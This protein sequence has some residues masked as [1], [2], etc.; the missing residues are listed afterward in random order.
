MTKQKP[1]KLFKVA[2][3][4][5]VATQSIVD[6]LSEN[7]FDV[8]NRPNSSITAEMYEVL[9]GVY[10]DDKEKS[11]E[12]ERAREEYESRRNQ[13]MSS[14]NESVTIESHL[15]PMDDLPLE[16][17]EDSGPEAELEPV[18]DQSS[19]KE[20]KEKEEEKEEVTEEPE[21]V[22]EDKEEEE[23]AAEADDEEEVTAEVEEKDE[24]EEVAEKSEEVEAE[25]EKE[26]EEE[27][28]TKIEE[29][30]E[31]Q[32]EEEEEDD[33][34]DHEDEEEYEDE[35]EDEEEEEKDEEDGEDEEEDEED[36]D[37]VRGRAGRLSGTK[38]LGKVEFSRENR[39]KR[40]KR[41]RRK[42][43]LDPDERSSRKDKKKKTKKDDDSSAKSSKKSKKK[44]SR[45]SS[46]V[47]EEDVEKKM[48]ETLQRIKEGETV[49]SKR[50]KRRKQRREEREEERAQQE[51]LEELE[52]TT[53]E[54]TEFITVSDLA[55]LM[56]V[57]SNDVIT[58]CMSL[59]MMVSINQRLDAATIELVAEEYGY[60]VEFV[61]AEEM[62]ED[63]I[64]VEED[65]PEDL[66]PRSPIITVMG[67]VDHGKTSLLDYIRKAK[68]AAGEAG[69]ITQHV[70]AYEVET[71]S[72]KKITFLDTPGHEAFTAMR[73]RGAQ[74]TDIVILV[75]AADDAVMP[76]TI[77]AINHSKAAGVPMVVAI[78]KMD[79]AGA[80]PDK[81]KSQLSEHGVIVE[82]YGGKNQVAEV[83]AHTGEGIDE[84]LEKVLIE[85]ELME[86]QANPDRLAQ[87]I[88]LESRIDKGKGTVAN[89]LIQ[90]GTLKV[91]D[92]FVAG[93]VFGRVRAMENEHGERLEAAG[94][95]T[96]IQLT[97][98]DD[99]PQAGDRLIVPK[100]EKAAKE[101]ANQRQ[102]IRRE[103]SL[104]QTKHLTLD[105][106]S[107]RMALGEVSE[108]NIIIKADV[109]GSIEAL[110][111]A[112]QKLS[113]EEVS[114]NIIHTGSGA[115]TESDVLLASASDAIIIGF[116]VRPTSTARKLAEN[117]SIDIRLFSVIYDAV[118]EVHDALEG[119]LSP[120]IK[121]E[122]K[123]LVTV[124]EIFKIS[125]VGTIAGCYVNEGKINRNNP[126]RIIR[127][128]VVIYD[129]EIDTLKRFKDDVKEV[130][131][132]YE[133]GISIE[134]F[135][136][137]KVGDE[138]ESYEVV[139]E[140]RKLEDAR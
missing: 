79:K 24:D 70:G 109:D 57:K 131:A 127:D 52:E 101:I 119:M 58:T 82:E 87:G 37:V 63:E 15:E 54:V 61:D 65:D 100:E 36:E 138:F 118:D 64:E 29:G 47:D 92:P 103:Q 77:E 98:F 81:I 68:V 99:T 12:H 48:K 128:G 49:G 6:T 116:Q 39:K 83:S 126:I 85:A 26:P 20:K 124:R 33:D 73:S 16:P 32:E 31:D 62:I 105:D 90:N 43:R 136:D 84:L 21:E 129:G 114:V 112:L 50:Q 95:S 17:E 76:Q 137:I 125:R 102:Q 19:D 59:G 115:I 18:D 121:E 75:V 93:P 13:I 30:S 41:K 45:R 97:G 74:A 7:G 69:G 38:V 91:G 28:E 88:V 134:N 34:H 40:K 117:E 96:P 80:N 53:L 35:D 108:L 135:N 107:R 71:D 123:G 130:Q 66:E 11:I 14:R 56:G 60:D 72:G 94:P 42:D 2:S 4:F 67:H 106:L 55:D 44:R 8:T 51:E 120:E 27:Q 89:I 25:K 5:N 22:T 86:L 122:M 78:N 139:E 1:K 10:G 9:E 111:G 132:G 46:R 113:T 110:S 140:K 104:R 133:C 23:V 3:E